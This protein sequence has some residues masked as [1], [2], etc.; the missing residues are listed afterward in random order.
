MRISCVNCRSAS[1]LVARGQR[2]RRIIQVGGVLGVP[3]HEAGI[4]LDREILAGAAHV[5]RDVVDVAI[6][7]TF[8]VPRHPM[9]RDADGVEIAE[10]VVAVAV[11]LVAR[12]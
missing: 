9:R 2:Q 7:E 10:G 1:S 4:A 12:K 6:G 3:L 8:E 5:E 11:A